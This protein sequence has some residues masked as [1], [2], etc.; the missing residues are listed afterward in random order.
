MRGRR[1]QGDNHHH[2]DE[3]DHDH[4][5]YDCDHNDHDDI[6]LIAVVNSVWWDTVVN[7]LCHPVFKEITILEI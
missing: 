4:D 3:R 2:F 6:C 7:I 5:I 1:V